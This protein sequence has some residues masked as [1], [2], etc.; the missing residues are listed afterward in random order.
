M[1]RADSGA[2]VRARQR[3]FVERHSSFVSRVLW[4]QG[5]PRAAIDDAAQQVFLVALRQLGELRDERAFLFSVAVRTAKAAR[6]AEQ[7]TP[8]ADDPA[9]AERLVDGEPGP[10]ELVGKKRAREL[11]D[12][13]LASLPEDVRT[14]FVLFEIEGMTMKDIAEAL[15]LA[16]G[17][18]ASRLRRARELFQSAAKRVRAREHGGAA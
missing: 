3:A 14:V 2:D 18:V 15:E 17:T 8:P 12:E 9:Q 5:V 6:R 11:L 16:P 7:R 1:P 10:D 13:I 4:S